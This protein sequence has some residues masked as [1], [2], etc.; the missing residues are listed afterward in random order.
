[1][2]PTSMNYFFNILCQQSLDYKK[3]VPLIYRVLLHFQFSVIF[4][5]H[6]HFTPKIPTFANYINVY[7]I[8]LLV[9]VQIQICME[10]TLFCN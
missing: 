1:M 7:F 8:M 10:K 9:Q 4:T 2:N 5:K 3:N 6:T